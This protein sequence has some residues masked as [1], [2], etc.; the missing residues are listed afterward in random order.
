MLTGKNVVLGVT[1]GIAV[2]KAVDVA[3]RLKKLGAEVDVIMTESATEFVQPLTFRSIT[4]NPVTV[5][6]FA[7]PNQWEVEH[8]SLAQKADLFLLA[9][10]TANIIGKLANGI[11]DDMLSTTVLATEA[12]VV[13]APAMNVNMY[14][15]EVV[16]EN[17]NYLRAHGYRVIEPDE[18][19]LA[20]GDRG[21]GRFPA[22]REVVRTSSAYLLQ[23]DQNLVGKQVLVT[24]GGTQEPLDPVR[25]IGN[26]SSGK[27]GYEL[28]RAAAARGAEVTLVSAPTQLTVPPGVDC[29]KVT[30]AAE[31]EEVVISRQERQDMIVMAAAVADY[32][33][34]TFSRSKIKKQEADLT[35]DLER[36]TDILAAVGHRKPEGQITVGFAA[37][38]ENL[39]ANAKKKLQ[40]KK[41]DFIIA[42]DITGE[43]TGFQSDEN[44]VLVLSQEGKQEEIPMGDKLKIAVEIFAR[45]PR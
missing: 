8:I 16:Q 4:H 33:P 3:S 36:T 43:E 42:N 44:Q 20:C 30:T 34:Q 45:L 25:F 38:T 26:H 37:E 5:D 19:Y 23:A 15:N 10:A 12:E 21:K 7:E 9:P 29:V 18:G 6:M 39:V 28:A 14:H 24:A 35:L 22:P 11:A 31:M 40:R 32:T 1:G 41:A 27:M 17:L 2:Y 13:L